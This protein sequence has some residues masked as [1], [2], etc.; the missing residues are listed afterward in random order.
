MI[1]Y[2][3]KKGFTLIELMIVVSI[4]GILASISLPNY[5][6]YIISA[7]LTEGLTFAAELK[8]AI[9]AYY[10][11]HG[12]FPENNAMAGLPPK[13][14]LIS[15][16]IS[17]VEIIKGAIH[18]TFGN[19]INAQ[20]KDKIL[21]IRPQYIAESPLTPISWLCGYDKVIPQM[22]VAGENKTTIK[23]Q[24]LPSSCRS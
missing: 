14:L 19:K 10:K 17:Q 8:P 3:K 16:Y 12:Y 15:N 2:R 20:L 23:R 22:Q 5:A 9:K 24:F 13:T 21:T 7:K 1:F 6:N 18:I 4:I 11:Q